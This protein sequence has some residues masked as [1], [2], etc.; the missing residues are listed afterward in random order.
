MASDAAEPLKVV[1]PV[2]ESTSV[3]RLL[4]LYQHLLMGVTHSPQSLDPVLLPL[5]SGA[6]PRNDF[7]G[8][9]LGLMMPCV[10]PDHP[11]PL[12]RV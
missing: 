7:T 8:P 6:H 9:I 3:G 11:V 5:T 10:Y 1:V 2:E 4:L 12:P